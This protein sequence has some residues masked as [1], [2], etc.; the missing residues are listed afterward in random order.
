MTPYIVIIGCVCFAFACGYFMHGTLTA[1]ER[2][3]R[4]VDAQRVYASG[5]RDGSEQRMEYVTTAELC[6]E[7]ICRN[8][9]TVCFYGRVT[10]RPGDTDAFDG[11]CLHAV[12]PQLRTFVAREIAQRLL[13][14][15]NGGGE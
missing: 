7:I 2:K 3:R 10:V 1:G 14:S 9:V 13:V 8:D 15:T 4:E 12:H 5:F 6:E 11:S